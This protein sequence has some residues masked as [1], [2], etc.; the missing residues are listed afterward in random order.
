VSSLEALAQ[1]QDL[2]LRLEQL[3]HRL[4]HL[5]ELAERAELMES[6]AVLDGQ[7][8]VVEEQ[9]STL[10]R[11]QKRHEDEVALI[12]AQVA[13]SEKALYGGAITSPKEASAMQDKIASLGRHQASIED[14]VIELME[15]VEP[16]SEEVAAALE[17]RGQVEQQLSV[18]DVRIA[19]ASGEVEAERSVVHAEREEVA[20]ATSATLIELYDKQRAR[21]R[22]RIAIGRLTGAT[23]GACHLD[24]SA[25][26]LDR[27]RELG[28]EQPGECAECGALLVH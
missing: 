15:Q 16:L 28:P 9:V 11:E 20:A 24:L 19:E 21:M 25:V 4:D 26:E 7:R 1:L 6:L 5:P 22:G 17:Q 18:V 12:E 13:E 3:Q 27:I 10:Q 8:A 2:D 23:C 14:Q